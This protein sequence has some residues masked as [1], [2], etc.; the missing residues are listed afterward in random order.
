M[1]VKQIPFSRRHW[2]KLYF[3]QAAK[4]KLKE[5]KRSISACTKHLKKLLSNNQACMKATKPTTT[6]SI[7][8]AKMS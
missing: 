7:R 1:L 3:Q 4:K 2:I 6:K 5:K 8:A